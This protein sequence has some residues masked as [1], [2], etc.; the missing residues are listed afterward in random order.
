[1]KVTIYHNPGCSKSRKALEMLQERD[2]ELEIVEYLQDPPG[3]SAIRELIEMSDSDATEFVRSSDKRFGE[4]GLT[5]P[6]EGDVDAVVSILTAEPAVM[7]RPVV[8][9]GG[10]AVIARP[11]ERLLEL[12]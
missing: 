10:K 4:A 7:Q 12:L 11:P 8:V 1:M 2:L 6:G 3:G 5:A 9:V